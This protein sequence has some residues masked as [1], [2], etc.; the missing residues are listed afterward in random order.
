M[1]IVRICSIFSIF[2]FSSKIIM[3]LE[4]FIQVREDEMK[5]EEA[6]DLISQVCNNVNKPKS[7][8]HTN[9]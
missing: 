1:Q 3:P 6:R 7:F 4:F 2:N 5:Q 8:L 9:I